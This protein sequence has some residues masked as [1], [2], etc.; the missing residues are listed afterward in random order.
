MVPTL[1]QMFDQLLLMRDAR[2]SFHGVP[3]GHLQCRLGNARLT[4]LLCWLS[5]FL[6]LSP[7]RQSVV[8]RGNRAHD[9]F[10]GVIAHCSGQHAH[11][12]GAHPPVL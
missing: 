11:F 6:L 4:R 1:L 10:G 5:L 2:T 3:H 7:I 9:P 8:F 12:F